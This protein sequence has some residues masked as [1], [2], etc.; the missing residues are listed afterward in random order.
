MDLA[1]KTA[2][3]LVMLSY[4]AQWLIDELRTVDD[5]GEL[6]TELTALSDGIDVEMSRKLRF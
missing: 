4:Y 2:A 6:R 3:E 5:S 1:Q